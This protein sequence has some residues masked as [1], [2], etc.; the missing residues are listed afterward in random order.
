MSITQN[1]G[2]EFKQLRVQMALEEFKE[3]V[4]DALKNHDFITPPPP[5][6]KKE[7]EVAPPLEKVSIWGIPLLGDERTDS[8]F[9]K[10]LKARN[11]D[12]KDAFIMLK[13]TVKW[14]QEYGIDSLMDKNNLGECVWDKIVFTHGEDK[15]GHPV[16]YHIFDAELYQQAFSDEENRSNFIKWVILFL[17]RIIRQLD[18]NP[19]GICSI[20]LVHDLSRFPEVIPE[21]H[22][23]PLQLLL[24]NY[25]E[26][27]AGQ[28]FINTSRSFSLAASRSP[29]F[30]NKSVYAA[31]SQ[32]AQTLS[33]YISSSSIPAD[34]L[35]LSEDRITSLPM[36]VMDRVFMQL[37][38]DMI[39]T[40]KC[41]NKMWHSCITSF[42]E[43]PN[44]VARHLLNTKKQPHSLILKA[45]YSPMIYGGRL[46][47]FN[48]FTFSNGVGRSEALRLPP[49]GNVQ[50]HNVTP[51]LRVACHCDGL[52]LIRNDVGNRMVV[53][54]PVMEEFTYLPEPKM[55]DK[56]S[57]CN[58]G[59]EKSGDYKCIAIWR[60]CDGD[61]SKTRAE[62]YK[63]GSENW[64]EIDGFQDII[65]G[66]VSLGRSIGWGNAYYW[67]ATM[68]NDAS[69]CS[70]NVLS[71]NMTEEKFHLIKLP[72][73]LLNHVEDR[74]CLG[75]SLCVKDSV[76]L[77]CRLGRP[78][79]DTLLIYSLVNNG[80]SWSEC[81]SVRI[82]TE[83]P[84]LLTELPYWTEDEI[85]F[86]FGGPDP[87]DATAIV[88]SYNIH[89]ESFKTI[90]TVDEICLPY[91]I[92]DRA[93]LNVCDMECLPYVFCLNYLKSLVSVRRR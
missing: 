52:L 50:H 86:V 32:S 67:L 28:V 71:F 13:N 24:N 41:L 39:I 82:Q 26:I 91:L 83:D 44:F 84:Y 72:D 42:I 20:F 27:L 70:N 22:L 16:I 53:C 93:R 57:Y 69:F 6:P 33:E 10:F 63:L 46:T 23:E 31:P 77:C 11:F 78:V 73:E 29:Y 9:L 3:V 17:E 18:F 68:T 88:K 25:P 92:R 55:F 34:Q 5:P 19:T 58:L 85:P 60:S 38:A 35:A 56:M 64:R 62:L 75:M 90:L 47:L 76:V 21:L 81:V 14:R 87:D 59:F 66:I 8:I 15:H 61:R 74:E 36:N 2:A 54:N 37:P 12:V 80:C 7:E 30:T 65:T 48:T 45:Y 89:S 79:V 4:Q 49:L 51:G 43:D 1:R 40:L